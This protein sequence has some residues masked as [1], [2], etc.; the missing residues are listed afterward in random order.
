MGGKEGAASQIVLMA[1]SGCAM[2]YGM[3]FFIFVH[4]VKLQS[5]FPVNLPTPVAGVASI[6][7][8]LS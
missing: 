7:L 6:H 4:C 3:P 2:R 1:V 5:Q 8:R